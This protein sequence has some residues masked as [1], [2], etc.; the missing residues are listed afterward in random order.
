MNNEFGASGGRSVPTS[1]SAAAS[2][3]VHRLCYVLS[4]ECELARQNAATLLLIGR[5]D[6]FGCYELQAAARARQAEIESKFRSGSISPGI[7]CQRAE[8]I[9]DYPV[10]KIASPKGPPAVDLSC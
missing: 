9:R 3:R 5:I 7:S 1:S 2:N 10:V 8:S 6:V 4:G